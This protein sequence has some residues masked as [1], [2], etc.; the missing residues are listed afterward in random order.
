MEA[1]E[2]A[3][4][5]KAEGL[6]GHLGTQTA[7]EPRTGRK[8]FAA[9]PLGVA[10]LNIFLKVGLYFIWSIKWNQYLLSPHLKTGPQR[11][12]SPVSPV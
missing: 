3:L 4:A 1:G 6:P 7:P 8:A 5:M 2:G 12:P 11:A 10:L 9:F